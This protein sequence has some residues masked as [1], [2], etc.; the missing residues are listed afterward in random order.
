MIEESTVFRTPDGKTFEDRP[1]AEEHMR[2]LEF[3]A[4]IAV[5]L[6]QLEGTARAK[7]RAGTAIRRFLRWEAACLLA[8]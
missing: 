4:R 3:E 5:Y 2:V 6:E 1:A 8:S 7:A